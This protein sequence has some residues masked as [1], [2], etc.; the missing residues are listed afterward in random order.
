MPNVY[1]EAP[2]RA[3]P[4][5]A[6]RR[7][8]PS[9]TRPI[10]RGYPPL[11]VPWR[12][13]LPRQ[14]PSAGLRGRAARFGRALLL[15]VLAPGVASR[16]RSSP[17]GRAR[18]RSAQAHQHAARALE[19]YQQGAY[20]EAI[21]ELEVA[22]QARPDGEGS[23][24]QSRGRPRKARRHRRRAPLLPALRADGPRSARAGES[25]HV[26]ATPRGG[27]QRGREALGGPPAPHDHPRHGARASFPRREALRAVRLAHRDH[28]GHRRGGDRGRVVPGGEGAVRP[29]QARHRDEP[30]PTGT[31]SSKTARS[32]PTTRPSPRTWA[33]LVG[34]VGLAA[35]AVL[36][37]ARTRDSAP[38]TPSG[39]GS[40]GRGVSRVVISGT[41]LRGGGAVVIEARF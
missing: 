6:P 23:R 28:A 2:A 14:M 32:P 17:R 9:A 31:R 4:P 34:A 8:R 10:R 7:T 26:P 33:S 25:G 29:P 38:A 12:A 37:L 27:T 21:G 35:T 36:F 5:P 11:A 16:S 39:A 18:R 20:H 41:P 1:S 19:L 13:I 3:T 30:A 24:L 22:A 40:T 15:T